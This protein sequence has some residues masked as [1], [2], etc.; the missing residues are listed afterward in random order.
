VL[1]VVGRDDVGHCGACNRRSRRPDSLDR[2]LYDARLA[3][4]LP[5][6]VFF[7]FVFVFVFI[8]V[9]VVVIIIVRIIIVRVV[10]IVLRLAVIPVLVLI[11][12]HVGLLPGGR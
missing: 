12:A 6:L 10:L 9:V 8:I 5:V 11:L 1:G 3:V 2:N 4:L 7:V